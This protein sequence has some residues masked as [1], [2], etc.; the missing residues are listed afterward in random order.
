MNPMMAQQYA[1][2]NTMVQQQ[3]QR[4]ANGGIPYGVSGNGPIPHGV[5]MS[6]AMPV[7]SSY[8]DS[9]SVMA[10]NI[11]FQMAPQGYNMMSSTQMQRMNSA[12]Q[13]IPQQSM[14]QQGMQQ[15]PHQSIAMAQQSL[16]M[17]Q[18][19]MTMPQQSMAMSH[20]NLAAS[21]QSM[22]QHNL[23]MPHQSM[24]SIQNS[25]PSSSG[26]MSDVSGHPNN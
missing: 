4:F 23:Q 12:T 3:Q 7:S 13:G 17:P 10:P 18:Q 25:A 20:Q 2:M 11:G 24:T 8:T 9:R 5:R 6:N 14:N 16:T 19:S 22:L 26:N 15:Q 21:Q 1:Q